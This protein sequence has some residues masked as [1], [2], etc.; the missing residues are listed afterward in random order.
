MSNKKQL[1]NCCFTLN[2]YTE[3]EEEKLKKN[4]F[5]KYIVFGHEVGEQGTKHLQGY[6]EFSKQI[7]IA[8][9]NRVHFFNRAH[10]EARRGT[11]KQAIDYC[12]KEDKENFFEKGKPNRGGKTASLIKDIRN[13]LSKTEIAENHPLE[14]LKLHAGIDKLMELK[15]PKRTWQMKVEIYYGKTGTGK[16]Y[17]A[18]QKYPN[19]YRAEWPTGGRWW[20][21]N[22][23]H[24]EVVILDEFRE[25]IKY[26][27][28]LRLLDRYPMKVEYKGGYTEMNSKILVI[29]T[30]RDPKE[31]Y[32]GVHDRDPLTRRLN[33][34]AKIY[35]C[36]KE[37]KENPEGKEIPWKFN[38]KRRRE[39]MEL[40]ENMD[41]NIDHAKIDYND[42]FNMYNTGLQPNKKRKLN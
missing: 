30:N 17:Y 24:E 38:R 8:K 6:C 33:E 10:L 13:G 7:V 23:N 4:E 39:E 1:R 16:S 35:D 2:N 34:F 12:I 36:N 14:Y 19:A 3:E 41:F 40:E 27:T 21:P 32:R 42:E 31:W 37:P 9:L 22:Y 26:D 25:Q 5:F 29:T 28:M 11:Q 15:Q 20:W 18:N